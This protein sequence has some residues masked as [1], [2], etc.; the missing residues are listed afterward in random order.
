MAASENSGL[1][2]KRMVVRCPPTLPGAV[3]LAA[4]RNLMTSSEYI[5]RCVVDRLKAEG[6]DPAQMAGAA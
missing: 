3:E 4:V 1:H 5:R 2:T 6:I